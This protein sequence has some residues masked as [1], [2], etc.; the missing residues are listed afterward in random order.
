MF[1]NALRTD[2]TGRDGRE[3]E[4]LGGVRE[5][6]LPISGENISWT[7]CSQFLHKEACSKVPVK[8]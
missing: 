5:A 1:N 4:G 3:K 6:P 2:R 8:I 7:L